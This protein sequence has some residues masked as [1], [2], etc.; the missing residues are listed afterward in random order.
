MSIVDDEEYRN[1]IY[2]SI[3]DVAQEL[4]VPQSTLR[5]WDSQ[6]TDMP[7]YLSRKNDR[8]TRRYSRENLEHVRLLHY[9]LKVKGYTIEGAKQYL[10][11]NKGGRNRND[12]V[13]GRLIQIKEHLMGRV[14]AYDDLIREA[15]R[16][17]ADNG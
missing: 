15:K 8:G 13:I 1:R 6:F 16:K 12:E 7:D 14:A 5:F 10:K 2:F 4:D 3:G 17:E 9:L 11:D